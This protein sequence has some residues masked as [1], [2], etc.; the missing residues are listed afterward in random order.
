MNEGTV[1]ESQKPT[2]F[3]Q[4]TMEIMPTTDAIFMTMK[5]KK[6]ILSREN[7]GSMSTRRP[8]LSVEG[9]TLLGICSNRSVAI[10]GLLHIS[11][12]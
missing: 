8:F 7:C 9:I 10:F 6:V 4:N 2:Y 3:S 1:N 11:A 12:V 5:K